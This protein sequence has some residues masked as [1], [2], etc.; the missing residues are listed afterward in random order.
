MISVDAVLDLDIRLFEE[1][2]VQLLCDLYQPG[3]KAVPKM[4]EAYFRSLL[5]K[6]GAKC[7]VVDQMKAAGED[8]ILQ[9]CHSSGSVK[10]DSAELVED[11]LKVEGAL[12]MCIRDRS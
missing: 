8:K 10:I 7:K 9:I 2:W 11:G 6:N 1:G 3:K 5:V 12:E 4:K